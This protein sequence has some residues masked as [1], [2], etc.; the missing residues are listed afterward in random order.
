MSANVTRYDLRLL[1][2]INCGAPVEAMPQGGRFPCSYCGAFLEL[3]PRVEDLAAFRSPETTAPAAPIDRRARLLAQQGSR[4]RHAFPPPGLRGAMLNSHRTS[5]LE[6]ARARW[7]EAVREMDARP[8]EEAETRLFW[9]T[10]ML[11][12]KHIL[13]GDFSR[14]RAGDETAA[15]RMRD[16]IFRSLLRISLA[17]RSLDGGDLASAEA[18]LAPLE[19]ESEV[20]AVHSAYTLARARIALVRGQWERVL[21]LLGRRAAEVP[22]ELGSDATACMMRATALEGLGDLAAAQA[23]LGEVRRGLAGRLFGYRNV[24]IRLH[25][26]PG[27]VLC[28]QSHTAFVRRV[29][30]GRIATFVVLAAAV[31]A[32]VVFEAGL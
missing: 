6:A 9:L 15:E 8:S 10:M 3:A 4:S 31:A 2:C 18:W 24:Q 25:A 26:Y 13:A 12:T 21:T 17:A 28:R 29:W 1:L 16:P 30:L 20:L 7:I 11:R 5:D 14:A 23:A 32:L 19:P 22:I 27:L